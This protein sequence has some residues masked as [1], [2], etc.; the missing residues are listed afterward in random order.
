MIITIL[1]LYFT[2]A[3]TVLYLGLEQKKRISSGKAKIVSVK[4]V[5]FDRGSLHLRSYKRVENGVWTFDWLPSDFIRMS[6]FSWLF[7]LLIG[8]ILLYDFINKQINKIDE[9]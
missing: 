3:L 5:D 1:L 9:N 4:D 6:F 7:W 8:V 2:G